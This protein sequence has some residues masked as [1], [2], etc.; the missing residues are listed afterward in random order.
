[1]THGKQSFLKPHGEGKTDFLTQMCVKPEREMPLPEHPPPITRQDSL[2]KFPP[3]PKVHTPN[4]EDP[5]LVTGATQH[6]TPL[7]LEWGHTGQS[8]SGRWPPHITH[9]WASLS[10][11]TTWSYFW[12]QPWIYFSLFLVG[13]ILNISKSWAESV[14]RLSWPHYADETSQKWQPRPHQCQEGSLGDGKESALRRMC[15]SFS[16]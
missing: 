11:L 12:I 16:H 4:S 7:C 3:P 9:T 6:G 14:S 2:E 13:K 5:Y 10:F 15:P 8:A 1:M